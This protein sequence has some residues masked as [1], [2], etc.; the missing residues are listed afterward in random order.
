M[1]RPTEDQILCVRTN[2]INHFCSVIIDHLNTQ[3]IKLRNQP[4]M[5]ICE[6]YVL[7]LRMLSYIHEVTSNLYYKI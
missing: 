7:L 4:V 5:L 1:Y 6:C 3:S 2:L